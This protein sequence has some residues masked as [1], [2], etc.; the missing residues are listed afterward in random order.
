L[1]R[2]NA[3]ARRPQFTLDDWAKRSISMT[4]TE[5]IAQAFCEASGLYRWDDTY[6]SLRDWYLAGAAAVLAEIDRL[7]VS[8]ALSNDDGPNYPADDDGA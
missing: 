7:T 6:G 4:L 3:A 1:T 2:I 8:V 5:R